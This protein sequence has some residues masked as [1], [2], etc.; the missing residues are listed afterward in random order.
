[1]SERLLAAQVALVRMVDR[2]RNSERGQ[3]S[4]EYAGVIVVAVLLVLV[5]IKAAGGWGDNLTQTISSKLEQ[6]GGF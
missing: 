2:I 3:G 1:M 6:L 4:A 5:L